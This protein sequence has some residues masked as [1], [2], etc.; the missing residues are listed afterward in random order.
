MNRSAPV[1]DASAAYALL[2]SSHNDGFALQ[3]QSDGDLQAHEDCVRGCVALRS[4]AKALAALGVVA[5]VAAVAGGVAGSR[6]ATSA[7]P[8]PQPPPAA[9]AAF[10]NTTVPGVMF[11]TTAAYMV[12]L[13]TQSGAIQGVYAASGS[14]SPTGVE[15]VAGISANS[16]WAAESAPIGFAGGMVFAGSLS[17]CLWGFDGDAGNFVS[18][19]S[20]GCSG[21]VIYAWEPSGVLTITYDGEAV[22]PF[23]AGLPTVVVTLNASAV[24][25][26]WFD[27]RLTLV[28]SW[29]LQGPNPYKVLQWPS[30]LQF[31]GTAALTAFLPATPG[32]T[33]GADFLSSD[34][35][36]YAGAYP[37]D[38]FADLFQLT[39]PPVA[40]GGPPLT[41]A[42][43]T[44]S[45]PAALLPAI[46]GLVPAPAAVGAYRLFEHAY[47]V[48]VSSNCTNAS[49]APPWG[50]ALGP[51][52]PGS[53]GAAAA[54]KN[55]ISVRFRFGVDEVGAVAAYGADNG[56]TGYPTLID[57]LTARAGGDPVAGVALAKHAFASPV[58]NL[59]VPGIGMPLTEYP[60]A[61]FPSLPA[62]GLLLFSGYEG[63]GLGTAS[64]DFLPPGPAWNTTICEFAAVMAAAAAANYLPMPWVTPG[65]WYEGAPTLAR[66]PG[67]VTLAGGVAAWNESGLPLASPY[68]GQDGYTVAPA[69]PFVQARL[70][71][72]MNQVSPMVPGPA[73][74]SGPC[75]ESNAQLPSAFVFE[76]ITAAYAAIDYSVWAAGGGGQASAAGW[77][78][79]AATYAAAGLHQA[80]GSDRLAASALAFHGG[81]LQTVAAWNAAFGGPANW[82]VLPAAAALLR[83]L[84]L[85]YQS[86]LGLGNFAD[87][88]ANTCFGLATGAL[89]SVGGTPGGTPPAWLDTAS[90]LQRVALSRYADYAL[91]NY[92]VVGTRGVI[93][94]QSGVSTS[95]FL[96]HRC[97]RCGR[98]L[99]P[100]WRAGARTWTG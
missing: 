98:P 7:A 49:M 58:Y 50:C 87:S 59:Y 67:G 38:L 30:D 68:Y 10:D 17:G 3:I 80:G 27:L 86:P 55:S 75:N 5:I 77:G 12:Q 6:H 24:G 39:Y 78:A 13:S 95:T 18:A 22:S 35:L 1:R 70:A 41:V 34:S 26:P 69:A 31:Q 99:T 45:G 37:G 11:I 16:R 82:A 15:S 83:P 46:V 47:Q 44:V 61:V 36:E 51:S 92:T 63:S 71:A 84:V 88:L 53:T 20:Y 29:D 76:D 14:P 94:S 28:R 33:V 8:S 90:L 74:G 100:S 96:V 72:L 21:C 60:A 9:W 97:T 43:Y 2:D 93:S 54:A 79:H 57:K 65:W 52:Q 23:T 62:P 89:L 25:Q 85:S 56:L 48:N 32:V 64:P 81:G 19:C 73:G 91:T 42:V 40:P 4:R 66:L